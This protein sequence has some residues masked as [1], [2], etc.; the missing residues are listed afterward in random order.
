MKKLMC[1]FTLMLFVEITFIGRAQ[2]R[3]DTDLSNLKMRVRVE[4]GNP[5]A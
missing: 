3:P 2:N 1:L 4:N 5:S